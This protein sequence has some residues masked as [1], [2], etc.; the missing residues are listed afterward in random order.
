MRGRLTSLQNTDSPAHLDE[1]SKLH[2]V[3]LNSRFDLL[4][5]QTRYI[6]FRKKARPHELFTQQWYLDNPQACLRRSICV[7]ALIG[8]AHQKVAGGHLRTGW[9]REL[10]GA[11]FGR[12]RT[13]LVY[14][15]ANTFN[16]PPPPSVMQF[17][18]FF[19]LVILQIRRLP[20]SNWAQILKFTLFSN[21][22]QIREKHLL[23]TVY[24]RK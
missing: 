14:M 1:R 2:H 10:Q 22:I 16:P 20:L 9:M 6:C 17:Q 5:P 13:C 21:G 7:L 18:A 12:D 8:W 24:F 23:L 3:F 15:L 4:S 11:V 19:M